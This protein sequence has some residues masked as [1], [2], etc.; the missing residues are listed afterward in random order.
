VSGYCPEHDPILAIPQPFRCGRCGTEAYATDAEWIT[1][2]LILATFEQEHR[3]DCGWPRQWGAVIDSSIDSDVPCPPSKNAG[4]ARRHY[5]EEFRCT[6]P[7]AA[8]A[9]CGNTARVRGGQCWVHGP[10]GQE[11]A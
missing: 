9:R 3:R 5:R 8:G 7:N 2:T 6:A 1:G 4:R 10:A 11:G